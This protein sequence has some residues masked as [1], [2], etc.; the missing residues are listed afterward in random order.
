MADLSDDERGHALGSERFADDGLNLVPRPI[1]AAEELH[2]AHR[3]PSQPRS[4]MTLSGFG[5]TMDERRI[6][7]GCRPAGVQLSPRRRHADGAAPTAWSG[8]AAQ[9]ADRASFLP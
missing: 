3:R 4:T 8:P 5:L 1:R 2:R 7:R 6:R 9:N